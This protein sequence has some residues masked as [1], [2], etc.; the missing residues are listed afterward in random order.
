MAL[1]LSHFVEE[2]KDGLQ[3]AAAALH[4]P[5]PLGFFGE[6]SPS[7][8]HYMF[9]GIDG[10]LYEAGKEIGCS[11]RWR[12]HPLS[13]KLRFSMFSMTFLCFSKKYGPVHE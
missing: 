1:N 8:Y 9:H 10:E 5:T 3:R 13:F 12:D 7:L 4:P 6:L 2:R 11:A